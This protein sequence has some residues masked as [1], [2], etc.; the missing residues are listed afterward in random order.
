MVAWYRFLTLLN[1]HSACHAALPRHT[2]LLDEWTR[3]HTVGLEAVRI[4]A[5]EAAPHTHRLV[6]LLQRNNVPTTLLQVGTT[7][8]EGLLAQLGR[9]ADRLPLLVLQPPSQNGQVRG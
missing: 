9:T 6:D 5:D 8:A 2:G 7:E 1:D 3:V 4:V